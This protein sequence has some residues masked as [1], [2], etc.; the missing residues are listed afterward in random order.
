VRHGKDQN[1]R[2]R[3]KCRDCSKTY[4]ILTG[5]PMARARKPETWGQYL[6]CMTEHMSVRKI[7]ASGIG[8]HHVTV[9]RWRHRFLE[10]A[11][12]DNAA[13]L[14]GVIEADET[15]FPWS[16]K[17]SRGW[18]KGA[19]PEDRAARSRGNAARPCGWSRKPVPVLT[20]V[21]NTNRVFQAILASSASIEAALNGRIAAG[22]VLCSDGSAP[23]VIAADK[24][25]SEHYRVF[26]PESVQYGA[27]A[28]KPGWLGLRRVSGYHQRLKYLVN[29]LCRGVATY[30][31]GNYLGWHRAMSR[32]GFDGADLLSLALA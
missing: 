6:G 32:T 29:E 4:N 24:A 21:D 8:L 28:P 2:Q 15:F 5:T 22:S 19:P 20:A 1:G 13:M 26:F 10:A 3:F 31:L 9:W 7:V 18:K 11:A 30:Y 12:N 17:G 23:Y 14:S 27:P 16:Y 25:K